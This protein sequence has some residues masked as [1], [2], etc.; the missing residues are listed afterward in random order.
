M[1]VQ[2]LH[3]QVRTGRGPKRGA[4]RWSTGRI[5]RPRTN[6]WH[7]TLKAAERRIAAEAEKDPSVAKGEWYIDGPERLYRRNDE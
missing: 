7:R 1:R 6:R 3:R 5:G 2:D 4:R